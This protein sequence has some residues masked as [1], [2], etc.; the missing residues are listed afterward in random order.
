M[1]A[2]VATFWSNVNL[3]R[4]WI[5]TVGMFAWIFASD[6]VIHGW[7]LSAAYQETSNL[8][9]SPEEMQNFMGWMWGGQFLISVFFSFIFTKGYEGKGWA[10]GARYGLLMGL[11][12]VSQLF[13][14]FAVTPLPSTIFWSWVWAGMVQSV[15]GGMICSWIYKKNA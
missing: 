12:S 4:F 8:W 3:K 1:T 13:I 14:N 6:L 10:E 11:F 5:T 7:W 15:L 9:R 2:L